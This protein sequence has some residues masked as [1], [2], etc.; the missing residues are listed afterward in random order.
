MDCHLQVHTVTA[1]LLRLS[2]NLSPCG[3]KL[4]LLLEL[5]FMKLDAL[6]APS[7]CSCRWSNEVLICSRLGSVAKASP[8]LI[9]SMQCPSSVRSVVGAVKTFWTVQ[10]LTS[11]LHHLCLQCL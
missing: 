9:L 7:T 6:E 5:R 1:G 8:T 10:C 4:A 3:H 2:C 11:V